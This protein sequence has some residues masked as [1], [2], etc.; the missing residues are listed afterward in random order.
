MSDQ[1]ELNAE[2]RNDMGKG[3]SRRLR[4]SA[5]LVPAIIYGGDKTPQPI[6]LSR[7]DLEKALENEAFYTHVLTVHVGKEKEKTIL[8]DLQR[9]PAKNRVMHADFMRIDDNV[10]I[11]VNVPIHFLNEDTCHGVKLQGGMIQHQTTD[12]EVQCLP[13]DIPAYIEVDMVEV[14]VGQIVHLSDITLPA[15]VTSVAL[16]LGE[17]HDLAVASVLAP[18]GSDEEEEA[19]EAAEAGA[20]E[21]EEGDTEAKA[22]PDAESGGDSEE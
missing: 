20:A 14:E 2:V 21:G 13:A 16:A 5:D 17:D 4:R 1:F 8:K 9:H 19:A 7:K 11:K 22:E 12:I 6:S 18:R 3:A 10:A 15:G